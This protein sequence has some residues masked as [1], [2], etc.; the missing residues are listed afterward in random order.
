MHTSNGFAAV[1]LH[2]SNQ[3][4]SAGN[5]LDVVSL[6]CL[7]TLINCPLI[8]DESC[9]DR[10]GGGVTHGFIDLW[11]ET[12]QR[13]CGNMDSPSKGDAVISITSLLLCSQSP[14]P[15]STPPP[16]AACI[17]ISESADYFPSVRVCVCQR[18]GA[19]QS[20]WPSTFFLSLSLKLL[21]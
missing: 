7:V 6:R 3:K 20:V 11:W 4:T 16:P 19:G 17:T 21:L 1:N 15:L 14:P 12:D 13:V 5:V 8:D 2:N 18:G 9:S 10:W